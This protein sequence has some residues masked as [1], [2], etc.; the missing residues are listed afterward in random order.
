MPR[1]TPYLLHGAVVALCVAAVILAPFHLILTHQ[2]PEEDGQDAV[3]Q[4]TGCDGSAVLHLGKG[5]RDTGLRLGLASSQYGSAKGRIWSGPG[6]L[7]IP[8]ERSPRAVSPRTLLL[9]QR[10]LLL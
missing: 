3:L 6:G 2:V 7:A 4:N 8:I 10:T 5:P 1:N 9:L